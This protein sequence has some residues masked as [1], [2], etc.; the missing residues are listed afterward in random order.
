MVYG[1][2]LV[3]EPF[4][5]NVGLSA[6]HLPRFATREEAIG[7]KSVFFVCLFVFLKRIHRLLQL[8]LH[9]NS[10]RPEDLSQQPVVPVVLED[11]HGL[12]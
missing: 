2:C 9:R 11:V 5:V 1:Q 6:F 12:F 3:N 4:P 8:Y 10:R 7:M